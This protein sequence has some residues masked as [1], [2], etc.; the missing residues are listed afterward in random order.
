[1][2]RIVLTPNRS[3][4]WRGNQYVILSLLLI[5]ALISTGFALVGAWVILPF[6]GIEICAL[7][8]CLYYVSWKLSYCHVLE[9]KSDVLS[10]EKGV[11]FPKHAWRFPVHE[12]AAHVATPRHDWDG[13]LIHLVHR[14]ES[15]LVGEFL[16]KADRE[17]LLRALRA[18]RLTVRT[19]QADRISV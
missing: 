16:N 12:V 9:F 5:S 14:Q 15:I 3:L 7:A 18:Q 10:V 1:M 19:V 6:A 2:T 17:K 8:G 4:N 11:Y 13:P